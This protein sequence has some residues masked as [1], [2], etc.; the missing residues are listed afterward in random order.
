MVFA[1]KNLISLFYIR[2]KNTVIGVYFCPD[3]GILT[4]IKIPWPRYLSGRSS[5]LG[6]DKDFSSEY[7]PMAMSLRLP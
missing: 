2:N 5:F 4:Y 3:Q 1:G 7:K 6:K